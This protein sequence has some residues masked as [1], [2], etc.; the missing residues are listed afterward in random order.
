[1]FSPLSFGLFYDSA[2][3]PICA[4][5]SSLDSLDGFPWTSPKANRWEP[6]SRSPKAEVLMPVDDEKSQ[7]GYRHAE[8]EF[9][10]ALSWPPFVTR[11]TAGILRGPNAQ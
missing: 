10:T 2:A 3:A 1:M 9:L 6:H 5:D 8:M 7:R 4:C 11:Q